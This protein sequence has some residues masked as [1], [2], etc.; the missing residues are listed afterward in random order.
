MPVPWVASVGRRQARRPTDGGLSSQ[1]DGEVSDPAVVPHGV[2]QSQDLEPHLEPHL[3]PGPRFWH[4]E[5]YLPFF[6]GTDHQ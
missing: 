4:R 2:A 5:G 1:A 6:S 3:T